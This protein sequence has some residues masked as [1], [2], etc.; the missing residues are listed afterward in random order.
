MQDSVT[1]AGEQRVD[2]GDM[3]N[4]SLSAR[5]EAVVNAYR[6]RQAGW[7]DHQ[8]MRNDQ[9]PQTQ[10]PLVFAK[11]VGNTQNRAAL[12]KMKGLPVWQGQKS[13]GASRK[14]AREM[15]RKVHKPRGNVSYG[16][17]ET[18]SSSA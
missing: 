18:R 2:R 6:E 7:R 9:E 12:P 14:R 11:L 10:C 1:A 13:I 8:V 5:G 16:T 3:L 15:A 17:E 4:E